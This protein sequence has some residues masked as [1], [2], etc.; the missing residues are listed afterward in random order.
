MSPEPS[1]KLSKANKTMIRGIIYAI[2]ACIG[3]TIELFV[4]KQTRPVIVF[5]YSLIFLISLYYIFVLPG[6]QDTTTS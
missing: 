2:I 5:G 4:L 3:L 6:K 1:N